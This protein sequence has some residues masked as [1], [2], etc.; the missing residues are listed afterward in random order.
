MQVISLNGEKTVSEKQIALNVDEDLTPE[1]IALIDYGDLTFS[2]KDRTLIVHIPEDGE[3]F[4]DMSVRSLNAEL[5]RVS[6]SI[7]NQAMKRQ[8]M[9]NQIADATGLDLD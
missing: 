7:N 6:D 1:F 9:L 5:I 8:R 2:G 4:D 3:R